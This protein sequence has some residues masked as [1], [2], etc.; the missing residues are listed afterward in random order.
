MVEEK[1]IC[2]CG[3]EMFRYPNYY[4][5]PKCDAD[6][7]RTLAIKYYNKVSLITDRGGKEHEQEN[8]TNP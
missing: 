4:L 6:E 7:I 1:M 8:G 5:C 3:L 2:M